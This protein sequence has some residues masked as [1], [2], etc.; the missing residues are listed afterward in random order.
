MHIVI[1]KFSCRVLLNLSILAFNLRVFGIVSEVSY[2]SLLRWPRKYFSN[3]NPLSVWTALILKEAT[4]SNF[5]KKSWA[6]LEGK[7]NK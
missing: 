7:E 5:L 3:S 2:P 4:D 1:K 6:D